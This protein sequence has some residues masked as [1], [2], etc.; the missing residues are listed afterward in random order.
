MKKKTYYKVVRR[1]GAALLS[2]ME[3]SPTIVTYVPN[4]WV[5]APEGTR[6]FVFDDYDRSTS[7]S[8]AARVTGTPHDYSCPHN[9]KRENDQV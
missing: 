7:S 9:F 2:A 3:K 6:L 8:D 5:N 1:K 4:E